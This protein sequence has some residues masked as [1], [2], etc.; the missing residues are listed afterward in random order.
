MLPCS[1]GLIV[2]GILLDKIGRRKALQV[3]Y[4]SIILSWVILTFADSYK[5]ILVAR[6]LLGIAFGKFLY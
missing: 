4:I 5:T 1:I 6:I 3:M 2:T